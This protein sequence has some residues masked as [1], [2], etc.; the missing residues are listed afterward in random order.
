[1]K[2]FLATETLSNLTHSKTKSRKNSNLKS[3]KI[4]SKKDGVSTIWKNLFATARPKSKTQ[5]LRLTRWF[6][7]NYHK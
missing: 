3:Q 5:I 2:M 4:K 6:I 1:M 7:R